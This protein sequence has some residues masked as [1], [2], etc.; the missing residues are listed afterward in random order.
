MMS[1]IQLPLLLAA[2]VLGVPVM[3]FFS[4]AVLAAISRA[5]TEAA[6]GRRPTVAVLIPAH[7]E[8]A[9]IGNTLACLRAQLTGGDRLLVVADNCTDDTAAVARGHGAEVCERTDP[10]RRG[11]GYALDCGVR[12][13][14]DDPPDVLIIVDADCLVG[15]GAV[16]TLARRA[17]C[18]GRPVQALYMMH[19]QTRER[20]ASRIAEFAWLVKNYVRP[21]GWHKAGF[22]CQLMGTGMAFPWPLISAASLANSH[23]VEDMKLGIEL[24]GKGYPPLFCREA[25]VSSFF[26]LTADGARAQRSRWEHGHMSIIMNEIPGLLLQSVRT[27]NWGLLA[28]AA[29]LIVPPLALL[30]LLV[31]GILLLSAALLAWNGVVLPFAAAAVLA[32]ALASAV[33]LSWWKFGRTVVSPY[34]LLLA[35]VYAVEKIPLY[36]RYFINKQVEWIRTERK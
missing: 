22:P 7:N 3:V 31:G 17:F 1:A 13:L 6:S 26:P 20:L 35:V 2:A 5:A 27:R 14:D 33:S 9:G 29:D 32:A 10:E 16:G 24:A 15:K 4:Q 36:I 21:L 25:A 30:V 11:K 19:S 34:D 28:L 12:F 23:L 18:T 8:E